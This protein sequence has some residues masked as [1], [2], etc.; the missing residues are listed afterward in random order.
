MQWGWPAAGRVM[1]K[2]ATCTWS[3]YSVSNQGPI[4]G[5]STG[6]G[7]A[8]QLFCF[9]YIIKLV[10]PMG[11]KWWHP[12][13]GSMDWTRSVKMGNSILVGLHS[14][15]NSLAVV[16]CKYLVYLFLFGISSS[17]K[18]GCQ[19]YLRHRTAL[20]DWTTAVSSGPRKLNKPTWKGD[21]ILYSREYS[22]T[23]YF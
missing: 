9:N 16:L 20:I 22:A 11:Q 2:R 18:M 23:K 14:K 5:Y 3:L 21:F 19:H 15:Q 17:V 12:V 4:R 1:G 13:M 8:P 10:E 7:D 6:N